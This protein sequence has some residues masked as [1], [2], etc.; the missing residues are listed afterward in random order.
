MRYYSR[1][2]KISLVKARQSLFCKC[3]DEFAGHP[4][5]MFR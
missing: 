4:G 5:F 1:R 2:E 3:R